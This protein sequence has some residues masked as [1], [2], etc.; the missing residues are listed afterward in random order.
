MNS[1]I[2]MILKII[3]EIEALP[4]TN[5]MSMININSEGQDFARL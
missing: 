4:S 3:M 1:S 5:L 2:G